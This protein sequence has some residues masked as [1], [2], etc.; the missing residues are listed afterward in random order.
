MEQPNLITQL[1][2]LAH[3]LEPSHPQAPAL[4]RWAT[5]AAQRCKKDSWWRVLHKRWGPKRLESLWNRA[6][7]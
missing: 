6:E 4:L 7:R 3:T 2:A 1:T 5:E